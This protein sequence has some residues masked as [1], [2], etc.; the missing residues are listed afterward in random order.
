MRALLHPSS[1][2]KVQVIVR[3]KES[4]V[5]NIKA[6]NYQIELDL[7]QVGKGEHVIA[8]SPVG[9]PS[10]VKVEIVPRR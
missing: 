4:S 1:P 5:K 7:T 2:G 10:A 3:G 6:S 9:I 8:L